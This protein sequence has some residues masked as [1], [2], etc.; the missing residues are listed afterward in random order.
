MSCTIKRARAPANFSADEANID[1]ERT[2]PRALKD[3]FTQTLKQFYVSL[4]IRV[5]VTIL[6][7]TLTN[8]TSHLFCPP[9]HT[10]CV[11]L[12][13][14]HLWKVIVV[15]IFILQLPQQVTLSHNNKSNNYNLL[16]DNPYEFCMK[17]NF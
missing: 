3:A 8:N 11:V 6:A 4:F 13:K 10:H 14:Y 2:N 9:S 15:E 16:I 12:N 7:D 5:V 1:R 17:L